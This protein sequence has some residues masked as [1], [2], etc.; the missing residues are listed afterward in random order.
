VCFHERALLAPS[1]AVVDVDLG[2]PYAAGQRD[3]R[4]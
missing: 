4:D 2:E 3:R 1:R